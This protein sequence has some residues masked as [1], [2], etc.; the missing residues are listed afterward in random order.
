MTPRDVE[1]DIEKNDHAPG[2]FDVPSN[3]KHGEDAESPSSDSK[4]EDVETPRA[5]SDGESIDE[6]YHP[7]EGPERPPLS[8]EP[9]RASS[10]VRSTYSNT[11]TSIR[12]RNPAQNRAYTHPLTHQKTGADVLVEFEGPDDPY[13]P[14]NWPMRKKVITTFLYGMTTA[15]ATL[16]SS[17]YSAG[18]GQIAERFQV[19]REVSSLGIS[20]FLLGFG[21]GPLIWAPLSEVYGRKPAVLLPYFVAAVFSIA[22][23]AAKDIQTVMIT[24][25][26]TGFFGAAPVTNTGGVL[27]DLWAPNQRAAALVGYAY[28]V[29]GGPLLGPIIGG[30]ICMSDPSGWRWLGYL[31]G[32]YMLLILICDVIFLDESYGPVLL[33]Y[34]ARRLRISS[35]NWA[36][37]SKHEEWDISIADLVKKYLIRPFQML[38]TPICFLIALYASFCYGI[39][40][41]NLGAFP[42]IFEEKRGWNQVVGALPFLA[43]LVGV[44]AAG[45]IN[46]F[47]QRYYVRRLNA[48]NGRPVPEARLPPMMVGS[49]VFAGGLFLFAWTAGPG[50]YWFP[51]QVGCF[52]IGVGFFTIFQAALNYLVDTFQRYGASAI[53]ANTFLRSIFA[54]AFPLFITQEINALGVGWGIT[55]FAFFAAALIPIPYLFFVFVLVLYSIMSLTNCRFYEDKYPDVDSF[56]MVNVRQIAEM[57]AYVK[58]LEYDD[59]DGM[60]LLSELSRRRIRSIQKLIRVGRNEVVVVLRVDKDKGYIDL[61]KRRVSPEDILKCEERYN[62]SKMAHSILRHVAEKTQIPILQLYESIGWPLNR[63][64]GHSIDAFKLSITNPDVWKEV[65]FP[66]EV[67]RKEIVDYI[68]KRLTPQPTKVRADVE[69]T[70]FSYE[71]IDAIKEALR[72][73]EAAGIKPQA[74]EKAPNGEELPMDPNS[75][76]VKVKLVSPPLYV[77]TSQCL[78]KQIGLDTLR[79]AI[80]AIEAKIRKSGGDCVV[81]MQPKAVTESDDAELAA[82]MEKRER[83]NQEVS[84]DEDEEGSASGDEIE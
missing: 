72:A 52:M 9:S 62:K 56:V 33:V 27:G 82:L 40:Y 59:I 8:R 58:L 69:V 45:I 79:A 63:K 38:L 67:V 57:G 14:M 25:F 35:G 60:I 66:D 71:G 11:L 7:S 49:V 39:L 23:G 15:G 37:H 18:F 75:A 6:H 42:T 41:A 84:G 34:K 50:V 21:T 28:A 51:S 10:I 73:G 61:S 32:I 4:L 26:F 12:S 3:H 83:E 44:L 74:V 46:L 17:I 43:L 78:D 36:L 64:Y 70:C 53:A 30:A 76:P 65:K 47:N 22:S 77:L 31:P 29:A 19:G 55:V 16:A 2:G 81:R 13:R 5:S 68:S 48:N 20:L 54:A 1:K 24:R 80:G